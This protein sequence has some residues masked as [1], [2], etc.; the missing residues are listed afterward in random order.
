MLFE[1]KIQTINEKKTTNVGAGGSNYF[2]GPKSAKNEIRWNA[3][4]K[5]DGWNK[6][7]SDLM[8][9]VYNII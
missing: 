9:K 5:D 8:E 6:L 2:S 1:S 7:R 4:N 3:M